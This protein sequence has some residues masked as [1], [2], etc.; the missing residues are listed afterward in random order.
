M[1]LGIPLMDLECRM[2]GGGTAIAGTIKV[3]LL[4]IRV[5]GLTTSHTVDV[6]DVLDRPP[7]DGQRTVVCCE[8]LRYLGQGEDACLTV[9]KLSFRRLIGVEA[10]G[11][12]DGA[13]L[14]RNGAPILD[15]H[16]DGEITHVAGSLD[17]FGLG[18]QRDVFSLPYHLVQLIDQIGAAPSGKHLPPFPSPT[19]DLRRSL[20]DEDGK[21]YVGQC[22]RRGKACHS[23]PHHE[24]LG[25]CFNPHGG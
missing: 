12:D 5:F 7:V 24:D 20:D 19:A 23:R 9:A 3:W 17:Q 13:H 15:S 4:N 2:H 18:E 16:L 8:K 22:E 1:D 14:Q 10:G 25:R 6:S 21:A 11:H